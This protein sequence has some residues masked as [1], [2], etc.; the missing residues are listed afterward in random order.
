MSK[1]VDLE[2][3]VKIGSDE[4]KVEENDEGDEKND[5]G[6]EESSES[7]DSWSFVSNDP[8]IFLFIGKM[9]SGK[10]YAVRSLVEEMCVTRKLWKFGL[11]IVRS[12]FNHDYDY[13][14]NDKYVIEDYKEETLQKYV[15]GL[16]DRVKEVG[17]PNMPH[18]FI[19]LDDM[20][21]NINLY[22]PFMQNWIISFRHTNTSVIFTSQFLQRGTRFLTVCFFSRTGELGESGSFGEL[23]DSSIVFELAIFI[24][25]NLPT[26]S[27]LGTFSTLPGFE[28]TES[29]DLVAPLTGFELTESLDSTVFESSELIFVYDIFYTLIKEIN[30]FLSIFEYIY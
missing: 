4:N 6:D 13:I 11:V 22:S 24:F 14:K 5:E 18:N 1:E 2:E 8:N 27:F 30:Y 7:I 12:K 25:F 21:G 29:V 19:V 26:P 23:G 15:N 16:R 28:L 9:R 3:K 17:K 10:T 20:L